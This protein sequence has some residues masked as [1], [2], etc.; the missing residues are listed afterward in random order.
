MKSYRPEE[1][2]DA[3]GKLMA[4][5]VNTGANPPPGVR[6]FVV[7]PWYTAPITRAIPSTCSRETNIG[8]EAKRCG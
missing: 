1:L 2:L 8:T 6:K 5:S 4:A 7:C 3:G